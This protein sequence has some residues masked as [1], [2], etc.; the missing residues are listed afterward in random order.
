MSETTET[1]A[2]PETSDG[3]P[4]ALDSR[5]R[6]AIYRSNYRGTKEMDWLLGKF[7]DAHIAQMSDDELTAYEQF[8]ALADPDIQNWLMDTPSQTPVASP[9]PRF[10]G[11]IN[12]IRAFHSLSPLGSDDV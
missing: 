4:A 2:A 10:R 8:L 5:R 7:A 6:R 9:D 12:R 3:T 11:L 1:A